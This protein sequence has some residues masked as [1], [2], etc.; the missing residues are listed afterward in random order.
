MNKTFYILFK[1]KTPFFVCILKY[2]LKTPLQV[3]MFKIIQGLVAINAEDYIIK[4]T[5][6][7]T[8]AQTFKHLY[9]ETQQYKNS[10]F[11]KKFRFGMIFETISLKQTTVKV[12]KQ[13]IAAQAN[14]LSSFPCAWYSMGRVRSIVQIQIQTCMRKSLTVKGFFSSFFYRGGG[15]ILVTKDKVA[16][17]VGP[18]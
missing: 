6:T 2:R 1:A 8:N 10:F 9:A 7:R 14:N 11:V 3:M 13:H 15:N 5:R 4:S 17:G 16:T 18:D 12:S